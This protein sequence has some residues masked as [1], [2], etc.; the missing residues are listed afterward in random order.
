LQKFRKVFD[1]IQLGDVREEIKRV[2]EF[3]SL[4]EKEVR[5]VKSFAERLIETKKRRERG[6]KG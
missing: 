1:R 2:A 4:G 5:E 6:E 3:D